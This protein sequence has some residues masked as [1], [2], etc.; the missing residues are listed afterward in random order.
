MIVLYDLFDDVDELVVE[1]IGEEFE[2][3][4]VVDLDRGNLVRIVKIL[5]EFVRM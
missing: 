1:V 3:I 5:F 2:V 4:V